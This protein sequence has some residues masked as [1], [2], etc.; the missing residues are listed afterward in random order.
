MRFYSTVGTGTYVTLREAVFRGLPPDNGLY[1][2]ERIPL[3][4]ANFLKKMPQ[5]NFQEIALEISQ[6]FMGEDL[7]PRRIEEIVTEAF[8]FPVLLKALEPGINVLELFHGPTLAF[9][10]FGARFMARLMSSLRESGSQPVNIL[11]ATSGDTGTAVGHG[12][13]DVEGIQVI[14]LYPRGKVSRIQEQQLTTIGG[15]V[16]ALEVNGTFDDCQKMVKTAFLDQELN[17]KLRLS[18][19]NSIN[20]ARL[21]PQSYYYFYAFSRVQELNLPVVFSVPSGNFGNLSAGLLA[22]R[23]GL[24]VNRFIAATNINHVV[25][26]YLTS[27][28]FDP[29]PSIATISNAMDVGNPSNFARMMDLYGDLPSIAADITGT[30][31]TDQ[32]TRVT[33]LEVYRNL[34]YTTC[35]HTA[36]AYKG[37]RDHLKSDSND[38]VGILLST[39]HPAKFKNIVDEVTG[40]AVTIPE[41]LRKVLEKEKSSISIEANFDN[42]K[43]YLLR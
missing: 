22:K 6:M 35:P 39:A 32:Q 43:D 3:I 18:S 33:M 16:Q 25:P 20:V 42:L 10:D 24:P 38:A 19:A 13:K 41:G 11:V 37:L 8:D 2:P 15:N 14:L 36:I 7:E 23:M 21:I 17:D 29:K 40:T 9:K 5:L 27:G 26:D 12:F 4:S 1:M 31:Y 28:Y 34:G 30:W